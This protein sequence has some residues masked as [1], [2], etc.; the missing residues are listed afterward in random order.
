M[1]EHYDAQEIRDPEMRERELFARL[2]EVLSH[3]LTAPGWRAHL[4]GVKRWRS[5]VAQG[6]RVA[7][8]VAQ[9]RASGDAEI[10]SALR[11]FLS[12]ADRSFGRL[13]TSPGPI[14]EPEGAYTDPWRAARGPCSLPGFRKGDIVLNT[15]S[16]H[17]TPGGFIMDSAARA[18]GCPVIPGRTRAIPSSS[19]TSMR[20]LKPVAYCGT[21][22]FLKIMLDQ[23]KE[24]RDASSIRRALVSGAAFPPSLQAD[25]KARGID[26]YQAYA[27]A[28]VGVIAY[29]S[30]GARRHDRQRR[31]H[32]EIVR[33]G[34][35]D[36]VPPGEVG[37]ILVTSLDPHHPVIRLALGDMTAVMPGASQCGRTNMRIKGW[38]GRADQTAKVK[39]MFVRPEQIAEIARRH[40][41]LVKLRLVDH[42]AR[43]SRTDA[44]QGGDGAEA[45]ICS[46]A[47]SAKALRH[48]QAEGRRRSS[49]R[50]AHCRTTER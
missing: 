42:A 40:P 7:A 19:S 30:D 50:R 10:R 36:P 47:R 23:A 15:F 8:G 45:R 6:A 26:A 39:G 43:T 16:Y 12:R 41:E 18:I 9:G 4:A 46:Q 24:C 27:T 2:P 31:H 17:L 37:E 5:D 20:H 13:F 38:M 11:R 49:Q 28:D 14:F 32:L 44:L 22:D 35:G 29:E 48:H 25:I 1:S 34:T 3:A 33:P 21:P